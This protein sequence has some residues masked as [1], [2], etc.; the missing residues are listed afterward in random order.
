M[1]TGSLEN[2]LKDFRLDIKNEL[3]E[4]LTKIKRNI[5]TRFEDLQKKDENVKMDTEAVEINKVLMENMKQEVLLGQRKMEEEIRIEFKSEIDKLR[6]DLFEQ[7]KIENRAQSRNVEEA[8][9][10]CEFED[11]RKT[12]LAEETTFSDEG[13]GSRGGLIVSDASDKETIRSKMS[14]WKK[15]SKLY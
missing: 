1:L 8:K 14:K 4:D 5:C 2:E 12:K 11:F 7:V 10:E 9:C 6:K 3:S 15:T 13:R